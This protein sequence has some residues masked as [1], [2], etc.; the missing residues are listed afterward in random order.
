MRSSTVKIPM[1][2]IQ[3]DSGD[4]FSMQ[5]LKRYFHSRM[6]N[7]S[8]CGSQIWNLPLP[9]RYVMKSKRESTAESLAIPESIQ[10]IIMNHSCPGAGNSMI[11]IFQ[12]KNF[13]FLQALF[14]HC[15]SLV[16]PCAQRMK[17]C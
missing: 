11:G 16:K 15:I 5:V 12:K 13:V 2:S 17:R 10:M 3:T 14:L 9:L 4:I 8:E 1:H 6:R 7:L